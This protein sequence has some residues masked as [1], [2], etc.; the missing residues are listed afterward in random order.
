[1][2]AREIKVLVREA[3]EEAGEENLKIEEKNYY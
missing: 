1:M 2:D 3:G